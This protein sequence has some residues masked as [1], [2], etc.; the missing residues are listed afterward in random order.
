MKTNEI[1]KKYFEFFKL[2]GHSI[3]PS[4]SPHTIVIGFGI[5]GRKVLK[6]LKSLG[7]SCKAIES[8]FK[9][10]KLERARGTDIYY[11]DASFPEVLKQADLKN[12]CSVVIAISGSSPLPHIINSIRQINP[13]VK[14]LIRTQYLHELKDLKKDENLQVVVAEIETITELLTKVLQSYNIEEEEVS[15]YINKTRAKLEKISDSAW[16]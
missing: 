12:A 13:N 7:I 6:A 3:I 10:V 2:K 14:I 8:S 4:A 15:K 1:R 9:I 16:A 11:G 5:A